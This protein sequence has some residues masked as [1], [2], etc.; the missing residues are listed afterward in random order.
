MW[1]ICLALGAVVLLLLGRNAY[2][3]KWVMYYWEEENRQWAMHQSNFRSKQMLVHWIEQKNQK[4]QVVHYFQ[5]H[6]I[7][8]VAVYG[9]AEIGELLCRDLESSGITVVCAIDREKALSDRKVVRPED[10]HEDVDAV[11]VTAIYYFSDIYDFMNQ[12]LG[13]K[14]PIWGLDEIIYELCELP[15]EPV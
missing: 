2:L 11:I 14:T 3:K 5:A 7:K 9:M 8:R 4:K 1:M 15:Q 10:F 13:G 12:K 6:G